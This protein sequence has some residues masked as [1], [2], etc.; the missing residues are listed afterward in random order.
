MLPSATVLANSISTLDICRGKKSMKNINE[1]LF[2]NSS[3]KDKEHSSCP[4]RGN[5]PFSLLC[6][7]HVLHCSKEQRTFQLSQCLMRHCNRT[8]SNGHKSLHLPIFS[9]ESFTLSQNLAR[10]SSPNSDKPT[11]YIF[12]SVFS[13]H[14]KTIHSGVCS[15]KH[16]YVPSLGA[17]RKHTLLCVNRTCWTRSSCTPI[18]IQHAADVIKLTFQQLL[19]RA[20][21]TLTSLLPN[22]VD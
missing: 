8:G 4:Q 11:L 12:M 9:S 1:E 17:Y 7:H 3:F 19:Q 15:Y 21:E 14:F 2:H 20:F 22:M 18:E 16:S 13:P 10:Q 5:S 6:L